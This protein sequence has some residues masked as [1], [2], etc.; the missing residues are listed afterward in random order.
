MFSMFISGL[1]NFFGGSRVVYGRLMRG[2][3]YLLGV[4]VK[5]LFCCF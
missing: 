4:A 1:L 2:A 5:G 3:I